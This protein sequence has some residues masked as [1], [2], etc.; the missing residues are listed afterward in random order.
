MELILIYFNLDLMLKTKKIKNK[1]TITSQNLINQKNIIENIDNTINEIEYNH[2]RIINQN[3]FDNEK[4][5]KNNK[6]PFYHIGQ[7]NEK[8]AKLK[9]NRFLYHV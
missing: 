4:E 9:R 7:V 2:E 6:T 8:H 5:N 1:K 3:F